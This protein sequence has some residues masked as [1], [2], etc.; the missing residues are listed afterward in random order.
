M[1]HPGN[2]RGGAEAAGARAEAAAKLQEIPV[3]AKGVRQ[4]NAIDKKWVV[5]GAAAAAM[6]G[7]A[8]LASRRTRSPKAM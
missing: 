3:M 2:E 1:R 6:G 5:V 8:V 4:S 7:L